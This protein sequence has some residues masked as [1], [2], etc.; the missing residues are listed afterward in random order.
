[1]KALLTGG[2]G[3]I[4]H[5]LTSSLIQSGWEVTVIDNFST[6]RKENVEHFATS[7]QFRL[8]TGNAA[9]LN[10]LQKEVMSADVVFNLAASVGVSNIFANP[11]ECIENNILVAMGVLNLCTQ[12]KK[13]LIMFSSSEVYGKTTTYP[14]TEDS[15]MTI[16][17]YDKLRWG[18]ASSKALDDFL[19]RG[20]FLKYNLA[21]T[22]VRLFNTIGVRQVGEYGMVVPRFINCAIQGKPITVYGTGEQTRCFTDVRDVV[23]AIRLI[24]DCD[25]TAGEVINIGSANEISIYD[26]AEKI[27]QIAGG[28]SRIEFVSYDKAYGVNFEDMQRR[29]P[30]LEKLKKFTGFEPKRN[31]LETLRW[32]YHDLARDDYRSIVRPSVEHTT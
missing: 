5:H 21:V 25:A 15:D 29:V 10:I 14:F 18:Y 28:R 3:F 9:D 16:G 7:P 22:T 8:I 27:N 30:S 2:A 31:L 6:G 20:Y 17:S 4:G 1:M 11:I 12:Y 26:L 24:A 19:S 32:V 13:R 23:H